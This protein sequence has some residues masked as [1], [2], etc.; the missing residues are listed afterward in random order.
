[1]RLRRSTKPDQIRDMMQ[2][3]TNILQEHPQ[4]D[5]SGVPVRFSKIS[6]LSFDIDIFAY[7][8]TA[9]YNQYLKVQTEILLKLLEAASERNIEFAVPFSES[10]TVPFEAHSSVDGQPGASNSAGMRDRKAST[11]THDSET[12][13]L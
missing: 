11:I 12:A 2:A 5:A 7:V 1:L 6:D 8:L 3:V 9:D 10:L 4:I 13:R